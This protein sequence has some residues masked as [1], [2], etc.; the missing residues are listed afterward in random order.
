M[1]LSPIEI[2]Q[3]ADAIAERLSSRATGD[4]YLDALGAAALLACSVPTVERLTKSGEIPSVKL[5]RLRR[6]P[7]AG[8][9]ALRNKKGGDE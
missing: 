1:S 8:L 2:Q 9:L 4:V 7:R 6:Y 5:G 3:L